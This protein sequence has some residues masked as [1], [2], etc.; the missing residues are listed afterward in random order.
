MIWKTISQIN[1]INRGA[2]Y[3]LFILLLFGSCMS[4]SD[5]ELMEEKLNRDFIL[6]HLNTASQKYVDMQWDTIYALTDSYIP[7]Q[8]HLHGEGRCKNYGN[9]RFHVEAI[10]NYD[11]KRDS[12][13]YQSVHV[14]H[15]NVGEIVSTFEYGR[16]CEKVITYDEYKEK[17]KTYNEIIKERRNKVKLAYANKTKVHFGMS[18]DDYKNTS[19]EFRRNFIDGLIGEGTYEKSKVHFSKNRFVSFEVWG[20]NINDANIKNNAHLSDE[21]VLHGS[22]RFYSVEKI[23]T[24]E[25]YNLK[26]YD[27]TDQ[28]SSERNIS[29]EV[30]WNK[31]MK[32]YK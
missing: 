30:Y 16:P 31:Y 18:Y 4:K 20:S 15:K 13:I 27:Q 29:I 12:I 32:M 14:S 9:N 22:I 19:T 21:R 7:T 28:S 26:V 6:S 2:I 1:R 10:Y 25:L 3:L 17:V 24:C 8:L 11:S 5:R 23:Y